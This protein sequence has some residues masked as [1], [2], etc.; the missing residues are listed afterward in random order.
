MFV[1][2]A[3]LLAQFVVPLAAAVVASNPVGGGSIPIAHGRERISANFGAKVPGDRGVCPICFSVLAKR[4][5]ASALLD[6]RAN[7]TFSRLI[8]DSAAKMTGGSPERRPPHLIR[9]RRGPK[10]ESR[11]PDKGFPAD[12]TTGRRRPLVHRRIHFVHAPVHQAFVD[13][14]TFQTSAVASVWVDALGRSDPT[15]T[16]TAFRRGPAPRSCE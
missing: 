10:P 16:V 1:W 14:S 2:V 7:N 5:R 6:R 3:V 4:P 11:H 12:F 15:S 9:G 8:S 13:A